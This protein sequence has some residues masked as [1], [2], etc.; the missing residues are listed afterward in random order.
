M[1]LEHSIWSR[2]LSVFGILMSLMAVIAI[3]IAISGIA[4]AQLTSGESGIVDHFSNCTNVTVLVTPPPDI[5][6]GEYQLINCT[7]TELNKW[8][9]NTSPEYDLWMETQTTLL[10]DYNH[11]ATCD[12]VEGIPIG[13]PT[14][15]EVCQ[16]VWTPCEG[17]LSYK[18]CY[19]GLL[20]TTKLKNCTTG[21]ICSP[22]WQC[23]NWSSC[24]NS[25]KTQSCTELNQCW[26]TSVVLNKSCNCFESWDCG[27]WSSCFNGSQQRNCSDSHMCGTTNSRP[28][29]SQSCTCREDWHCTG[30]SSCPNGTQTRSCSDLKNCGTSLDKPALSQSCTVCAENW[31]CSEWGSCIDDSQSRICTDLNECGALSGKPSESQSCG[32]AC[33]ESWHCTGW[34][35]CR[36]NNTE[37]RSCTDSN[38]CNTSVS[39]PDVSKSCTFSSGGGGGGGSDTGGGSGNS[40]WI[41][42]PYGLCINGRHSAFCYRDTRDSGLNYTVTEDCVEN[43]TNEIRP[44]VNETEPPVIII[45]VKNATGNQTVPPT[46][47]GP[48]GIT[49]LLGLLMPKQPWQWALLVLVVL[50]LIGYGLYR[51]LIGS[52]AAGSAGKKKGKNRKPDW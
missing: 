15:I 1:R 52:A 6:V 30:W 38:H 10:S 13:T 40:G 8:F 41:C 45:P 5:S 46:K 9:C 2:R 3:L 24:I 50:A 42:D 49:G 16:G 44:V 18:F 33:Q 29:L 28:S 20:N 25:T 14:D 11:T 22:D 37:I 12:I 32:V 39:K 34:S 26:T 48:T 31:Q 43:K 51:W 27:S 23:G 7:Q 21:A 4:A 47:K 36:P 17:D 35:S 19:Q